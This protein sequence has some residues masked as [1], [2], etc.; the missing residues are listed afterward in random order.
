MSTKSSISALSG[1]ALVAL[2]AARPALA[3]DVVPGDSTTY[4]TANVRIVPQSNVTPGPIAAHLIYLGESRDQAI[5]D[6]RQHG[7]QPGTAL[8]ESTPA[9]RSVP[10][11]PRPPPSL[12]C[13]RIR[14][15][16]RGC[17]NG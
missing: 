6:A 9:A 3:A 14:R 16:G 17:R 12:T 10:S 11:C 7:E 2:F 1:L 5:A 15:S 8:A 13:S 4:P